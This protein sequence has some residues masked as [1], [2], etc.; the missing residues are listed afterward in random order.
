[1]RKI[2]LLV[3]LFLT[4]NL[5]AQPVLPNYADSLF[6]TYYWQR[7]TLFQT[8]P[9]H[10]SDI[11]FLGNS[12]TDGAEWSEIFND[13]KIK[14]RGISGDI[15]AGV[16]K[17]LPNMVEGKPAKIFLLIG[18]NDLS[19]NIS[20][21]S[22]FTNISLIANYIHYYSA[23]TKLYVQS[24]LPVSDYYKKF[25]T[26]S[27]KTNL[28]NQLNTLL[29]NNA[30]KLNYTYINLHD[31]FTDENGKMNP[32]LSNDGLHLKGDGYMLWKHIV[33]PYVYNV[34][35][36]PALI[37]YP[38]TIIWNEKL[39]PF[40][41]VKIVT[42]NNEALLKLNINKILNKKFEIQL[43]KTN[44]NT[45]PN[46]AINITN[47]NAPLLK[48]EA[49]Q[50]HIDEN[51]LTINAN[52]VKAAYYALQTIKQ[53]ARD[54]VY[55]NGCNITDWPS[56]EWRG[57]MTDAGR[58][59]QSLEFLKQQ[60]DKMSNYKMNIFHFHITEDLAWRW[61][62]KKYPQLTNAENM[63]R[64][65]GMFYSVDDIK[66]LIKYC[67]DRFITLVPELDMPG[68]SAA[69]TKAMGCNMQ[70]EEGKK[71]IANI[72]DEIFNTYS[73]SYFH[74]GA[75]EVKITDTTFIPFVQK[76]LEAHHIKVIGWKPGG[77]FNNNTLL[78]LWNGNEKLKKG[79]KYIDSRHLYLNH[80]DPFES[81]V[82]IFGRKICDVT[83][84]TNEANGAEI[85]LWHDRRVQNENDLIRMN[86]VYP[87]MLAFSE[88][89]WNGGGDDG[90]ITNISQLSNSNKKLF[91]IFE[92]RM[93]EHK[94]LYFQCTAFPYYTQS[95]NVW[96][97]VGPFYNNGNL[98]DKFKLDTMSFEQLYQ[99]ATQTEIGN[100]IILRHW[101]N[102]TVTGV[103][104]NPKENTTWYA[105]QKMWS[106]TDCIQPFWIGFNNI[107]RSTATTVPA[108]NTW[109]DRQSSI[110]INGN[111]IKPPV[112][113][114][115]NQKI[116]LET[117]LTNEGYEYRT[118]TFVSL[119]KGWNE[120]LVKLP[121]ANF[122]GKDWQ[123]PVKWMFTVALLKNN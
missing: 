3:T 78:Q 52:T 28:I 56:F 16:I 34:E 101:W 109:D 36:K 92:D 59:Y 4:N 47:V 6:S 40:Y 5:L 43:N 24:I 85:C 108:L 45:S 72:L 2:I 104:K 62:I 117:P 71:I 54:E 49:Y 61:Q 53:L 37:P 11:I 121:V 96:K 77:N 12:I 27:T 90:Y 95:N 29:K 111:K 89:V 25:S 97:L 91:K 41:K 21:D 73:F 26:H 23:N 42:V 113:V 70:S 50:I 74:I 38:K 93:M 30:E 17:R 87:A 106:D 63:L 18:V 15:S 68:H 100:T 118:P 67:N 105:L 22:I 98:S 107:S 39:F 8:L 81:A 83:E 112:W 57:Y 76:I 84:E 119:K 116:D 64:D 46:I 31:Y 1:M 80:F 69:F 103:L 120:I 102:P 7:A 88:K 35:I 82:T 94:Q 79:F 65:K 14:N 33:F 99:L 123:N 86:A 9:K 122:T 32:S 20:V 48:E 58:N 60:I 13:I 110:W 115:A 75:D 44:N 55:I 19:R 66:E 114:N 10:N 51:T